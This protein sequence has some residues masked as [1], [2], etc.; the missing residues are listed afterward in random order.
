M[1]PGL[2]IIQESHE[3][4]VKLV[5]RNYLNVFLR[6]VLSILTLVCCLY[7]REWD[8]YLQNEKPNPT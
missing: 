3:P 7:F 2:L 6:W 4:E 1:L 8:Q 5:F